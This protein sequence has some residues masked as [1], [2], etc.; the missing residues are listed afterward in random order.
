MPGH[1]QTQDGVAQI[2]DTGIDA[3]L[4]VADDQGDFG[5]VVGGER[6]RGVCRRRQAFQRP[7]PIA[8]GLKR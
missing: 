6:D 2:E 3:G 1:R 4:F 7:Q 8:F 5:R